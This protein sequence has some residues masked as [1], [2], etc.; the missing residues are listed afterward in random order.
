MFIRNGVYLGMRYVWRCIAVFEDKI[1]RVMEFLVNKMGMEFSIINKYPVLI[2][3]RLQKQLIP[4][5]FVFQVLL[6]KGLVKKDAKMHLLFVCPEK[7]FMQ[8]FV[9]PHKEDAS[10]LL[11]LYKEKLDS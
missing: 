11:I 2:S 7:T 4:G 9:M 10:E 6:S 5:G 3:H 1:M 8:K